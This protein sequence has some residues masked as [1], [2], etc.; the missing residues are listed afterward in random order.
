MLRILATISL[1]VSFSANATDTP[2]E[3]LQRVLE[4]ANLAETYEDY[5]QLT[6]EDV[7]AETFQG[8]LQRNT[9]ESVCDALSRLNFSDQ[10]IFMNTVSSHQALQSVDCLKN[11]SEDFDLEIRNKQTDLAL[12]R[13]LFWGTHDGARFTSVGRRT[14]GPS[15]DRILPANSSYNL[16]WDDPL[17]RG[18]FAL[19]FDDGPHPSRTKQ[20]LDILKAQDVKAT[21]FVLGQAVD[22]RP[23]IVRTI[24]NDGHSLGGHTY[25]HPDLSRR[26]YNSAVNEIQRGFNTIINAVGSSEPFFRFPY[27]AKTNRLMDYLRGRDIHHFFWRIDTLD[28]KKRNPDQLLNYAIQQ[29]VNAGKG[30]ILFHDIHPQTVAMM[31]AFLSELKRRGY[32][33]VVYRGARGS[34]IR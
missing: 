2:S 15:E 3:V 6:Q 21:F 8:L 26:S 17:P 24:A 10:S 33:I 13:D 23:D 4:N 30:I 22:R 28:W 32:K 12:D 18:T 14:L 11:I 1:L 34:Q 29:T 19:T 27:G 16:P 9:N 7:L 25:T 31:P 5:R 20:I